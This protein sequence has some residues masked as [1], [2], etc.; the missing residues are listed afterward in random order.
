MCRPA[1]KWE[2]KLASIWEE[3]SASKGGVDDNFFDLAAFP[4]DPPLISEIK[5][6][7]KVSLGVAEHVRQSDRE[8][9]AR[10]IDD[11][12]KSSDARGG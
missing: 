2:L 3:F 6:K 9:M 7:H 1:P 10:L 12:A 11:A 4:D 8:A 5:P